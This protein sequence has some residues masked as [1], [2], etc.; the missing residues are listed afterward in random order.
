MNCFLERLSKV[1]CRNNA[2]FWHRLMKTV[3]LA[4]RWL[5]NGLMNRVLSATLFVLCHYNSRTSGQN[6]VKCSISLH[7]LIFCIQII[8]VFVY[9]SIE[10]LFIYTHFVTKIIS[11]RG[12]ILMQIAHNYIV[13]T[14]HEKLECFKNPIDV[15]IK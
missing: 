14:R 11:R 9:V 12:H 15:I 7:K 8:L 4:T 2:A 10:Y 6:I 5:T 13:V 1:T 3:N